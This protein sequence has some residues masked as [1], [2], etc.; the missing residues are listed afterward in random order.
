MGISMLQE[1]P[2]HDISLFLAV[3]LDQLGEITC[4]VTNWNDVVDTEGTN[5]TYGHR[6][7]VRLF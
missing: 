4:I 2:V 7:R 5:K 1:L 3:V 6:C